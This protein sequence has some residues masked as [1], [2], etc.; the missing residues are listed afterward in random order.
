VKYLHK[1]KL[2]E[3]VVDAT[4]YSEKVVRAVIEAMMETIAVA[5]ESRDRVVLPGFGTFKV[6]K[7]APIKYRHPQTGKKVR[8]DA[9]TL[10][11]FKPGR[12]LK[13]RVAK[14]RRGRPKKR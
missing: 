12:N 11:A 7:R 13:S 10:P 5:L 6:S 4:H 8:L 1:K 14:R 3:A 9:R 2:V